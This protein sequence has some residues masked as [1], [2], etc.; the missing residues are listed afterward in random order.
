MATSKKTTTKKTTAKKTTT[1][2][3]P[4]K[5]NVGLTY[6]DKKIVWLAVILVVAML[7]YLALEYFA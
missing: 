3:A 7:V 1:R 4:A 6:E 2:K 5:K